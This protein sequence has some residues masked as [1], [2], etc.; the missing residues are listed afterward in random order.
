MR[1]V[2]STAQFQHAVSS[3]TFTVGSSTLTIVELL[4]SVASP[5]PTGTSITWTARV[6]G[7]TAGP[8]QYQFWLYTGATGWRNAQPYGPSETFVWTPTWGEEGDYWLQ[9]WVR[10]NGSTATYD[11]WRSST[12]AFQLQSGTIQL[13]TPKWFPTAPAA[14][15]TWS[16]DVPN[17]TVNME[18]EFS[19]YSGATSQWTMAQAY[20]PQKTFTWTPGTAGTY[21]VRVYARQVGSTAAF[22]LARQADL[23]KVA[24]TPGLVW[25][26]T[27]DV[28]LPAAAGTTVT[29]RANA[30]G[31][32]AP[33]E[34]QFWRQ[35]GSTWILAQDYSPSN[36]YTWFTSAASVGQHQVQVRVRS[37]GSTQPSDS[38]VT[39]GVFAIQ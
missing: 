12:N 11:H 22:E 34:Y 30:S 35:D 21:S 2:G 33:L 14:P 6:Q 36:S 38:Q 9:V 4:P 18:Y 8:L 37:V 1:P 28:A 25:A 31:G 19:V 17:P 3:P 32:T 5:A 23:L 15:V 7:G 27:S 20:G 16:A 13:A 39:S 10:S 26:L 29:W 24:P